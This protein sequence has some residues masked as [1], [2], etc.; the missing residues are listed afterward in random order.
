[1]L[2]SIDASLPAKE[3]NSLKS[4][5]SETNEIY[6][7]LADRLRTIQLKN[8]ARRRAR[9]LGLSVN[10]DKAKACPQK[11]V[12]V[13]PLPVIETSPSPVAQFPSEPRRHIRHKRNWSRTQ[14]A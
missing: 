14:D 8:N 11:A 2:T 1:M 13:I 12:S 6:R 10:V 3:F 7:R 4:I 5:L 9:N